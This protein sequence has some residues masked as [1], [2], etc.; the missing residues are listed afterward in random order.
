[1]S[2]LGLP[3]WLGKPLAVF[4]IDLLLAGDNAVVIALVCLSLPPR[5]RRWVLLFG[6]LGAIALR[7]L[8][9]GLA[10]SVLAVPGLKLGGGVLLALLALNLATSD[11]RRVPVSPALGG[12]SDILAAALLV[13]LIDVLMSLDNVLALAAVAGDSLLYLGIGLLLS[14]CIVMFGSA[15]VAHLLRRIPTLARLGAA[16]LGWVA[17]QMAVSDAWAQGSIATQA[18]AL[19]LLVPALVAVYVYLLGRNTA[20]PMPAMDAAAARPSGR[21]PRRPGP[22]AAAPISAPPPVEVQVGEST[23]SDRL[24]LVIFVAV[25]AVAGLLLGMLAV[26]GN[27]LIR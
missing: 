4:L 8:L 26:I 7:V 23:H 24:P 17:G 15:L 6:A 2:V 11:P 10:W 5:S 21:P 19:P 16:L 20:R 3:D 13:T 12:R 25:F 14:V 1:M 27:G 18:P 9:T 22:A